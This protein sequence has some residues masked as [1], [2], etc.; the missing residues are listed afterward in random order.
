MEF[1]SERISFWC[2]QGFE[3]GIL[4]ALKVGHKHLRFDRYVKNTTGFRVNDIFIQSHA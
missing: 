1:R 3:D 2:H 4:K